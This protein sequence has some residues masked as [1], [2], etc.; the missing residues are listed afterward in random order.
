MPVE[1][2]IDYRQ[3]LMMFDAIEYMKRGCADQ[4]PWNNIQAII[5]S[6]IKRERIKYE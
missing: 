3:A 2:K 5:H 1:I 6:A 4:E